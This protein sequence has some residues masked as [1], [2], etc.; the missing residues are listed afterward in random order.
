MKR[1]LVALTLVA[2]LSVMGCAADQGMKAQVDSLQ[3]RAHEQDAQIADL[4]T[5]A[6]T[7][8]D[9]TVTASETAWEWTVRQS[10]DAWNSDT[11]VEART[12]FEKC[13]NDLRNSS[14]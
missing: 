10:K 3:K 8:K 1:G 13:W 12:R 4:K 11:S 6:A 9:K 2:S 7:L 14:K 5:K